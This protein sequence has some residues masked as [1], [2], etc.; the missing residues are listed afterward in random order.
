MSEE[1]PKKKIKLI[2]VPLKADELKVYTDGSC[3]QNPGPGGWAFKLLR[4]DETFKKGGSLY[5]CTNNI[6]E[7]SGVIEAFIYIIK[8]KIWLKD[9]KSLTVCSDSMYV[10]NG[11]TKWM[12]RWKKRAFKNVKN[13]E[14]W[15]KFNTWRSKMDIPVSFQWI[16]SHHLDPHN[17]EVDKLARK[18]MIVSRN[19]K[20]KD[21]NP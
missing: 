18:W 20:E 3:F 10:I 4:I 5:E 1:R 8:N 19:Q 7:L 9:M 12:D 17:K 14:L 15:M 2:H 11:A 6:C 13:K 16:K 21:K